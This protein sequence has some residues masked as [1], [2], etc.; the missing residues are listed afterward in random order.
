M[1][2]SDFA[3]DQ[4]IFA[5]RLDFVPVE[6]VSRNVLEKEYSSSVY[7]GNARSWRACRG[8]GEMLARLP[9]EGHRTSRRRS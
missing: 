5:F 1:L 8:R 9:G 6:E 3:F 2:E 7:T 4:L